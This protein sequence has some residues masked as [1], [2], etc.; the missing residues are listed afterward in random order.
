MK[1]A[2]ELV[3]MGFKPIAALLL[4]LSSTHAFISSPT[5]SKAVSGV[6][7]QRRISSTRVNGFLDNFFP[8][9]KPQ[10]VT[11]TKPSYELV[12]IDQDFRGAGLFLTLG[13]VLDVIPYIQLT[14][15]PIVTLLGVLF[16]VQ[17]FRLR[18]QFT[19]DNNFQ[20][21]TVNPL[22]GEIEDSGENV[23]VGGANRWDCDTI[24][25]YDFFPVNWIDSNPIGPILVYFKA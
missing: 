18:F 19:E 13:A 20:L 25:N 10:Q 16:L 2:E 7:R 22:T 5:S 24:V 15:G 1:L 14:L 8:A 4:L 12:T 23:I 21:V 9:T 17:T 11:E 6:L 3:T